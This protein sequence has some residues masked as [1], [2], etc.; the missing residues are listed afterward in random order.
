MHNQ[1]CTEIP[2]ERSR[3]VNNTLRE[4]VN[5]VTGKHHKAGCCP[6]RSDPLTLLIVRPL[7]SIAAF[8]DASMVYGS[9]A[10]RASELR[11]Y[12]GGKLK[13]SA[14]GLS[15]PYNVNGFANAG[16]TSS[17]F[18]LAGKISELA[19]CVLPERNE[20]NH[21]HFHYYRGHSSK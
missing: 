7:L 16:S 6:E 21:Y 10:A 17:N 19:E 20:S 15:L 4:Q 1:G 8:I 3:F 13:T 11:E 14:N 9:D 18:F 12:S 5:E 2:F